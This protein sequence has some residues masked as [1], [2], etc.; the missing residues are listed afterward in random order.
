M[1]EENSIAFNAEE[2]AA[3]L[4]AIFPNYPDLRGVRPVPNVREF[5]EQYRDQQAN[6]GGE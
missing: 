1:G 5:W 6:K 2:S 3:L 4:R